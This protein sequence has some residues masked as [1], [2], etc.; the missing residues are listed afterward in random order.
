MSAALVAAGLCIA[1]VSHA[2]SQSPANEKSGGRNMP[3]AFQGFSRDRDEPVKI[4][5]DSLEIHDRE[6][7]AIFNGNVVVQ[8]GDSTMRSRQLK[9]YYEGALSKAGKSSAPA[10]TAKEGSARKQD[11]AQR[12]RRLEAIGGV[13]ISSKD[14]RATGDLG[15][16]DMRSNTATISGNVVISQG[17]NVMQADRLIVDLDTGWSRLESASKD[18]RGRVQGVF[19]PGNTGEPKAVKKGTAN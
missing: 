3:N 9:V 17:P 11:P 2:P 16:F 7:Y 5:S 14:Q 6:R 18:G 1:A 15:V 13:I 19:V 4:E 10:M 12:I 8:Q